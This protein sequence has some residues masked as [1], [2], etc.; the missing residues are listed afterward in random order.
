MKK[1][2]IFLLLFLASCTNIYQYEVCD[3]KINGQCKNIAV[4]RILPSSETFNVCDTNYLKTGARNKCEQVPIN[5]LLLKGG[6]D[7]P[8][9]AGHCLDSG[10]FVDNWWNAE[11]L[12]DEC[13]MPV[14]S[15]MQFIFKAHNQ[16]IYSHT[17]TIQVLIKAIN[18]DNN[19]NALQIFTGEDNN[20]DNLPDSWIHC[21]NVDGI[22]GASVKVIHCKGN[23]LKFVKL[24]NAMWNKNSLFID[25]IE[26]LK[27]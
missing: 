24:V 8:C 5:R 26:V 7:K 21:G 19:I 10:D 22:H 16:T 11:G 4:T 20:N 17:G 6:T 12:I 2:I 18:Y 23:N 14:S 13:E 27:V 3:N 9:C 1:L 15:N 25:Y